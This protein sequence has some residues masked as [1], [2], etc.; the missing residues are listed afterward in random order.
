MTAGEAY[1]L[2]RSDGLAHQA[3]AIA[4][5]HEHTVPDDVYP[6]YARGVADGVAAQAGGE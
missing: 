4:G 1:D 2:G 3:G 5:D 6:A